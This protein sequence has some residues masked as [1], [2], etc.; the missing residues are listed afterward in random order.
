MFRYKI[1]LGVFAAAFALLTFFAKTTLAQAVSVDFATR[2]VENSGIKIRWDLANAERIRE[3]YY[4]PFSPTWN[5]S[6]AQ[7]NEFFGNAAS[8]L[9]T[10][11]LQDAS[12]VGSS[13][14]NST[15]QHSINGQT[16]RIEIHSD[17][18][19]G[20]PVNT[21]YEFTA[22]SPSFKVTRTFGFNYWNLPPSRLVPYLV[23]AYHRDDFTRYAWE[24][25]DGTVGIS[26]EVCE[27]SCSPGGW[28]QTW[29]DLEAP[30]LNVGIGIVNLG[31]NPSS[32]LWLDK[33]SNSNTAVISASIPNNGYSQ[34]LTVSYLIVPHTGNYS[35]VNWDSPTGPTPFLDLPWDYENNGRTF[36][37]AALAINAFFDHE[38]PLLSAATLQEPFDSRDNLTSFMGLFRQP[39]E[40]SSHDGYDYGTRAGARIGVP[41]LASAE[42]CASYKYT[43]LGGNTIMIDHRNGY[44]TR[45][46]HLQAEGLITRSESCV[47]VG[48]LQQIG[49]VGY[50]GHVEPE[51]AQGSHL[52]FMVIYDKNGDGNFSDNI[53][54]GVVD[55]FGWQS[56]EADPWQNYNFSYGGQQRSGATSYYLWLNPIA[57]LSPQLSAN[58]GYFTLERYSLNFP[59]G[60]VDQPLNLNLQVSPAARVS[61]VL[62][63]VGSSLLV[64][65]RD[66]LGN[67]VRSFL[68]FF[69]IS[70]SFEGFN[71]SPYNV[72]TLSIYSSEDGLNWTRE[73][74]TI[75]FDNQIAEASVNHLS[76]FALMGERIDTLP[77]E[78]DVYLE[79][80]EGENKWF[81]SDV[82]MTFSAADNNEGLGVDYT[83]FRVNDE[84]WQQYLS[85]ITFSQEGSY[86]IEFYSVDMDENIEELRTIEFNI[87]KKAP[88]ARIYYDLGQKKI[89]IKGIDENGT[90]ELEESNE[91]RVL[92]KDTAGNSLTLVG[93]TMR[94]GRASLYFLSTLIY[95]DGLQTEIGINKFLVFNNLEQNPKIFRF[96]LQSWFEKGEERI[97]IVYYPI[98][99]KSTILIKETGQSVQKEVRNGLEL[100]QIVTNRG[101]LE[102]QN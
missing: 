81:R 90:T 55:P 38:Y 76:Y 36:N 64:S 39:L 59:Q 50:T 4:K 12:L 35:K 52:H 71:L 24:K 70:I 68:N 85:P 88:E 69:T 80:K 65:A 37:E 77:P 43:G 57:N 53:P 33:D 78:T 23:R 41:V 17:N 102:V 91:R 21:V 14:S 62:E 101:N 94:N 16:A 58:G 100:L 19:N 44:Q 27:Y 5:L 13:N 96:I 31:D 67:I 98:T 73:N 99:N 48:R 15:W 1:L 86:R 75:D 82:L 63:S 84:D 22:D 26:D 56:S 6:G 30:D 3:F 32:E 42:G 89:V 83:L 46:L 20:I 45:Y 2:T 47:E 74:T 29:I 34:S 72:G 18:Q 66:L 61:N 93:R 87:D 9:P 97:N 54:D 8:F 40:Y 7:D 92:V 51:G 60:A 10:Q 25:T 49:K 28:K 11:Y 95:S 79:G